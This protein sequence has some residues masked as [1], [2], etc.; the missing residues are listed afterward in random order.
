VNALSPPPEP[1]ILVRKVRARGHAAHHGGAWKVAYADFVTAM[2]AFFL[3]MWLLGATDEEQ[4]KGIADYFAPTVMPSDRSGGTNGMMGG[5]SIEEPEGNAPH[6]QLSGVRPATP[7]QTSDQQKAQRDAATAE[8][9]AKA[10]E[11]LAKEIRRRVEADPGLR[12]LSEQL[13]LD[14]TEEGLRIELIDKADYSMFSSGTSEMDPRARAVL[15]LVAD[16]IRQVPNRLAVRGHT[17]AVPFAGAGGT[18]NWTLSAQR[19]EA[20]RAVLA[21]NGLP[22]S[23][24][25]RLEGL[26]DTDPFNPDDPLDPR[27]RRM[28]ITLL[29]Q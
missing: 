6:P 23:R 14:V 15:A 26:A 21:R 18:N 1:E 29:R 7:W 19:A 27:N 11:E 24:F 2:M 9:E 25:S 22:D 12:D 17:D 13:R 16:S 4:R 5:R 28:S 20:T 10:L 8:A 3:L